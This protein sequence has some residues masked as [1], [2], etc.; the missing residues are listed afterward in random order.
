MNCRLKLTKILHY[1]LNDIVADN[2]RS[3]NLPK[4]V[5]MKYRSS[6]QV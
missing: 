6:A 3:W 2:T 5:F 1:D 4:P